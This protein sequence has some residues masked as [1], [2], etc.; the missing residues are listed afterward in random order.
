MRDEGCIVLRLQKLLAPL[1][2]SPYAHCHL[3][4][5]AD[6][7][8]LQ[9]SPMLLHGRQCSSWPSPGSFSV[10]VLGPGVMPIVWLNH[11]GHGLSRSTEKA[12]FLPLQIRNG[13][14][15]PTLDPRRSRPPTVWHR[16][17]LWSRYRSHSPALP[18]FLIQRS[19]RWLVRAIIIIFIFHSTSCLPIWPPTRCPGRL[20]RRQQRHQ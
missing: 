1:V 11:G 13:C 18:P 6:S 19:P 3:F 15:I 17:F 12:Q 9:S 16:T 5:L 4:L 14:L 7:F 10:L 2:S 8:I 20:G